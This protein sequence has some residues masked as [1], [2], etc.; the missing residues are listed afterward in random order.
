MRILVSAYACEPGKGSEPGVGWNYARE[1]SSRHDLTVLTRANNRSSIE[2]CG[3]AWTRRVHW[4]FYDPPNWLVWWKR[5]GRGVQLFYL[6]WQIGAARIVRRQ[7]A[8]EDFD[9]IHHITFGK[10]WIP[11]FIDLS[12]VPIVFGPVGGGEETPPPFRQSYSIRGRLSEWAKRQAVSFC[13]Y[14][15]PARRAYR[16]TTLCLAA[17]DQTK[18]KLERL[19]ACPVLVFPQSAVAEEDRI[20]MQQIAESSTRPSHPLFVTACRLDHWKALPV[21]IEAFSLFREKHPDAQL[22]I[23]GTGPETDA[24]QSLVRRKG[25]SQNVTFSGRLPTLLDVYARIASATA[26]LHPALHEAFGQVCLEAV[27]L[28]TPVVC[29][30]WGGPGMICRAN[31]IEA[32]PVSDSAAMSVSGFRDRMEQFCENRPRVALS[33]SCTWTAW[34]ASLLEVF[35]SRVFPHRPVGMSDMD[36]RLIAHGLLNRFRKNGIP[37]TV[38]HGLEGSEVGRDL[39][40][41]IDRREW[42][43][44]SAVAMEFGREHFLNPVRIMGPFGL[45]FLFFG[46]SATCGTL[47]LHCVRNLDWFYVRKP[48]EIQTL[49]VYKR[50]FMTLVT[51]Q[52]EKVRRELSRTP[53]NAIER[54]YLD[55]F[56]KER[57]IFRDRG[58]TCF[59]KAVD[60]GD[61]EK[62]GRLLRKEVVAGAKRH[63][64]RVSAFILRRMRDAVWM[65]ATPAGVCLFIP[66]GMADF[67]Q[68]ASEIERR[69]GVLV[70][71]VPKD[72]RT[73]GWI[74]TFFALLRLRLAQG[75]QKA[76]VVAIRPSQRFWARMVVSPVFQEFNHDSVS[77]LATVLHD[78]P[79]RHAR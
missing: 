28:G 37:C 53:M 49:H 73:F 33:S 43:R 14:I 26:L 35:P 24:I 48:D 63:P 1:M 65:F 52:F 44:V 62:A 15:P 3:E 6:L 78:I 9:A 45:R 11:T 72:F 34:C 36:K 79:F 2:G 8:P 50:F 22:E 59:W 32:V 46:D 68:V 70:K 12:G 4:L 18:A 21:A 29:W 27:A 40:V 25:L 67:K 13:T 54:E 69:K 77:R 66:D 42:D 10:Y 71:V 31:G 17:T 55:G 57:C 38:I 61:F 47:E 58:R 60:A 5:G 75:H 74:R 39:D 56:L 30:D 19:V 51:M 23:I 76:F 20:E 64:I 16:R 41:W 7:F